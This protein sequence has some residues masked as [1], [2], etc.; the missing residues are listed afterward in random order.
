MLNVFFIG[1]SKQRFQYYRSVFLYEIPK[2]KQNKAFKLNKVKQI[3]LPIIPFSLFY[4]A[5]NQNSFK[6]KTIFLTFVLFVLNNADLEV[7]I[8]GGLHDGITNVITAN[9]ARPFSSDGIHDYYGVLLES[10][11]PETGGLY[12]HHF[13]EERPKEVSI[14]KYLVFFLLP[15][16]P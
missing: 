13:H 6:N 10:E 14:Q 8:T 4:G 16:L 3:Q 5:S 11:L 1:V 7:K 2:R 12:E 9:T 15:L